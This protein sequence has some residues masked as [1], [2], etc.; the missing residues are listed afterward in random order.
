MPIKEHNL[1]DKKEVSPG[2]FACLYRGSGVYYL[3]LFNGDGVDVDPTNNG[4]KLMNLTHNERVALCC[5]E[6]P[7]GNT[8]I[9]TV[10]HNEQYSLQH[11]GKEVWT[12]GE[13]P[14]MGLGP[15][16][17]EEAERRKKRRAA[18]RWLIEN[19]PKKNKGHRFSPIAT[20]GS[21]R[22]GLKRVVEGGNKWNGVPFPPELFG[23]MEVRSTY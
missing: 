21:G 16:P 3:H 10:L 17:D 14:P 5:T 2:V 6:A 1:A 4:F 11:H 8:F 9:W 15:T 22:G 13:A 7:G 20:S 18:R 19:G 23:R 12:R